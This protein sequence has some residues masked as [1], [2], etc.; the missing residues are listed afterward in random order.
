M[1]G[2]KVRKAEGGMQKAVEESR[3]LARCA[4]ARIRSIFNLLTA[5]IMLTMLAS[6][7]TPKPAELPSHKG[8]ALDDALAQFRQISSISA[9]AGLEYEKNDTIMSGDASLSAS[10]DKLS[11]RIYYLGFLQGE[12]YEEKGAIRSKP[13][14]D[15]NK[16]MLLVE[17]LKSSLFWWNINDYETFETADSYELRNTNRKVVISKESLLPVEQT[18]EIANGD[19][20]TISYAAPMRIAPDEGKEIAGDSPLGW[21]QSLIKIQLKN[22]IVRI[23]VKSYSVTR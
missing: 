18:I 20:L 17:G 23:N 2:H 8:L 10:P 3:G 16:S 1:S 9:V 15:K 5:V 21:Y 14:L 6:C 12:V 22:Y 4:L 13:K 19:V 7:A 11:L